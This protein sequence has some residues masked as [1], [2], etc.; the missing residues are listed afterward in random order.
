VYVTSMA[1]GLSQYQRWRNAINRFVLV[2]HDQ[3][4]DL[5]VAMST[6]ALPTVPV[7]SE[8]SDSWLHFVLPT[9]LA[10]R[11]LNFGSDPRHS[12]QSVWATGGVLLFISQ[13]SLDNS[14]EHYSPSSFSNHVLN[15]TLLLSIVA[16]IPI[17]I[18]AFSFLFVESV[19]DS[20]DIDFVRLFALATITV[21]NILMYISV[22][23]HHVLAL[24]QFLQFILLFEL[25]IYSIY[26]LAETPKLPVYCS[27][28]GI[29]M[30]M[31]G[32]CFT[33]F[34]FQMVSHGLPV[35]DHL[36]WFIVFAV[37]ELEN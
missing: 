20:I 36:A 24:K 6:A 28:F 25:I 17:A 19:D 23:T 14:V 10:S 16:S 21:P 22:F 1:L 29:N 11:I 33:A 34:M 12:L 3:V 30:D 4:A 35:G 32:I 13:Y 2:G 31:L 5:S 7:L 27:F 37:G 18:D 26:H 15:Q 8:T 9:W